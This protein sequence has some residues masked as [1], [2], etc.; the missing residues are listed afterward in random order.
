MEINEAGRRITIL[1]KINNGSEI[2]EEIWATVGIP[3]VFLHL[4]SFILSLIF[5]GVLL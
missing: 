3:M 4:I 2:N 1:P 5:G